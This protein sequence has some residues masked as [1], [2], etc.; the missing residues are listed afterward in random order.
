MRGSDRVPHTASR[1]MAVLRERE[2]TRVVDR[3]GGAAVDVLNG[4]VRVGAW[5]SGGAKRGLLI[6]KGVHLP[7]SQ[8]SGWYGHI[9]RERTKRGAVNRQVSCKHAAAGAHASNDNVSV[10]QAAATT[11]APSI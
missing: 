3:A 9:E 8:A 2:R 1:D 6:P 4:C 5:A 11:N 7:A 10:L